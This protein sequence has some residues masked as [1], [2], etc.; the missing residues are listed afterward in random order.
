MFM[1]VGQMVESAARIMAEINTQK[2]GREVI[3]AGTL[4]PSIHFLW[5][6]QSS[7][8]LVSLSLPS[9]WS[10]FY[11]GLSLGGEETAKLSVLKGTVGPPP[12]N[13]SK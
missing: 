11:E 3:C 13:R 6:V 4:N 7:L 10:L 2:W 5:R 8:P 9:V 1:G 12:Y